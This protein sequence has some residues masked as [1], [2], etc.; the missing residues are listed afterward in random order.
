MRT[1]GEINKQWSTYLGLR[2]ERIATS[3]QGAGDAATNTSSVTTP[4]WHLNYKLD[5]VGK[6]LI[7]ASITRSYKAPDLGALLARPSVNALYADT[8]K[9]NTELAPDRIGNRR[10]G[11]NWPPDWTWR[12]RN[13]CPLAASSA[14]GVFLPPGQRSGAQR[15]HLA[16]G[17]VGW[18]AALGVPNR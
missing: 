12:S 14:S 9:A 10:C 17:V 7:R 11:P 16:D 13:T 3:S 5:A 1:S 8:S 4:M 18:R 2:S 15:N 6:D